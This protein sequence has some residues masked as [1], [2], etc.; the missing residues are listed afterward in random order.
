MP[1]NSISNVRIRTGSDDFSVPLDQQCISPAAIL[2]ALVPLSKL[3]SS[4]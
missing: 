1:E 2:A 4:F 3:A